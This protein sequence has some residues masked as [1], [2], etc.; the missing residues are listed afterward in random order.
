MEAIE[1]ELKDH[2]LVFT[3]FTFAHFHQNYKV[4]DRF[5]ACLAEIDCLVSLAYLSMSEPNMCRPELFPMSTNNVF[6]EIAGLRHPCLTKIGVKFIPNDVLLGD[7]EDGRVI[8]LTGPNM[9]GKST[10]L[11]MTCIAAILAQMG[12]FVPADSCKFSIVDRIFTRIGGSDNM[13]Q[14]KST[15]FIEMEE[16]ANIVKY[17]TKH[18]L[19]IID[20]LGRGTSTVDGIAIAYSVMKYLLTRV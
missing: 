13:L 11:R 18:S 17:G 16:T 12:S 9:G 7:K 2:L 15:F 8:L 3:R 19:A 1:E 6:M 20:E 4:W 10:L 14:G 5:I